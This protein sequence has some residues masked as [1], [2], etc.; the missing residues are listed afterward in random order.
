MESTQ[1]IAEVEKQFPDEWLLFE[2]SEL[3]EQKQPVRGKLLGHSKSRQ[4]IH[5]VVMQ[6]RSPNHLLCLRFAGDPVPPDMVAVL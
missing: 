4:E 3:D 2:V 5:E 6:K 1:F